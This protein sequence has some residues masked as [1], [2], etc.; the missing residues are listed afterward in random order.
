MRQPFDTV[1][2]LAPAG[3]IV[4]LDQLTKAWALRV[5]GVE[6]A[7]Q[8]LVGP[9]DATLVF[10]HSNAFGVVPILGDVSRWGLA[11]FNFA[12]AVALA[13][14][15]LRQPRGAIFTLAAAFL[16]GGAVGN[17]IDRVQL[18]AVV[19]FLDLSRL[20]FHWV[21]NLADAS[22]DAGIALMVLA[23]LRDKTRAETAALG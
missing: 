5:L 2:R 14:W 15:V 17:A 6:G 11:A 22:V 8:P 20:G 18:G 7:T 12:V 4:L 21:F 16:M 19:D 13:V 10:N 9:M 23:L 1:V 3:V